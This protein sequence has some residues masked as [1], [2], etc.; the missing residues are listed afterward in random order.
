[1]ERNIFLCIKPKPLPYFHLI[2]K[3]F[4]GGKNYLLYFL[5][6]ISDVVNSNE[7]ERLISLLESKDRSVCKSKKIS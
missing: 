3:N 2:L 5:K 1:M 6:N 7:K 4:V